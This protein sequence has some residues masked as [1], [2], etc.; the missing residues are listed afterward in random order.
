[1]FVAPEYEVVLFAA[2]DICTASEDYNPS[3]PY[4]TPEDTLD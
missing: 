3:K 1:M 2:A 4:E